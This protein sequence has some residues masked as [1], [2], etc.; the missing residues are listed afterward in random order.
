[1]LPNSQFIALYDIKSKLFSS[2]LVDISV[3]IRVLLPRPYFVSLRK[4]DCCHDSSGQLAFVFH[5]E[6]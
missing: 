1:M 4:V 5:G 2:V 3:E 6:C